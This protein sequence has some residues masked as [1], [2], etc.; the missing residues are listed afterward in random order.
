[1]SFGSGLAS[2]IVITGCA[3]AVAIKR[4]FINNYDNIRSIAHSLI[5]IVILA[6]YTAVSING[7]SRGQSSFTYIPYG[8]VSCIVV[9]IL[10]GLVFI[11]KKFIGDARLKRDKDSLDKLRRE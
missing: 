3:I 2:V 10:V 6:L 4:P 8:V 1:M 5:S 11:I 7:S 9:N